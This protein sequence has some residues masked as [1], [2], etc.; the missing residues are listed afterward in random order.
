MIA[1]V[2][3]VHPVIYIL[4][5]AEVVVVVVVRIKRWLY[6]E[7]SDRFRSTAALTPDDCYACDLLGR[8]VSVWL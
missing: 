7:L 6:R 4:V 3:N 1:F 8:T 5:V 2:K